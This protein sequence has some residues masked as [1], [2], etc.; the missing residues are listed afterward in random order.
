MTGRRCIS[1]GDEARFLRIGSVHGR[2]IVAAI[3]LV[4][5][6]LAGCTVGPDFKP[7]AAPTDTTYEKGSDAPLPTAAAEP[8]QRLAVGQKIAADWWTLFKSPALDELVKQALAGNPDLAAAAANLKAAQEIATAA[9]GGVFPQID[10]G[11]GVERQRQN[12]AAFGLKQPAAVFNT[13][14]V[15]ATVSYSLD[16]F[17]KIRRLVEQRQ[18]EADVRRYQLDAIYLA[19]TGNVI[20][21]ALTM[22]SLR[23]QLAASQ[24]IVAEDER[25]LSLVRQRAD[26]GIATEAD[27][28]SAEAQF[29]ADRMVLPP[30][31]Q[32]AS[33]ARHALSVLVGKA[34]AQWSPPEFAL[35]SLVLPPEIPVTLPSELVHRRPDILAAEA[36]LHAASAAVGVASASLYPD[37]TLSGGAEQIAL[38]TAKFFT[39]AGSVWSLAAGV[40][41]PVFHGGAL[42]AQKRAAD[43]N[44]TASAAIYRRT[45]L[46]SFAQVADVLDGLRHDTALLADARGALD[47]ANHSLDLARQN[48]TA[49][50]TAL[51]DLLDAQRLHQ[52]ALIAYARVEA[53]RYLDTSA[54]FLAMGGGWWERPDLRPASAEVTKTSAN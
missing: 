33:V 51:L 54:L 46:E 29:A 2:R 40:A 35:D 34:P 27:V 39:P 14:S 12:Y 28:A 20:S 3:L 23:A 15:G 21:H 30:L 7:P 6:T 36:E 42:E 48:Y 25:T 4:A 31:Q 10:A 1:V 44:Y 52:R 8:A 32:Q 18:A 17:G 26:V 5:G 16:P 38:M 9:H 19:L 22:A 11:A 49:G 47:A 50:N 41:G 13:F 53:Q 45:V 37:I 43:D 24:E